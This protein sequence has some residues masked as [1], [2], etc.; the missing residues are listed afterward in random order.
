MLIALYCVRVFWI[1]INKETQYHMSSKWFAWLWQKSANVF[2]ITRQFGRQAK[3]RKAACVSQSTTQKDFQFSLI[4]GWCFYLCKFWYDQFCI[5][6]NFRM[7]VLKKKLFFFVLLNPHGT[8][9]MSFFLFLSLYIRGPHRHHRMFIHLKLRASHWASRKRNKYWAF[10]P[11]NFVFNWTCGYFVFTI[12]I[13]CARITLFFVCLSTKKKNCWL[14]SP[15]FI[16]HGKLFTL[17]EMNFTLKTGFRLS[18]FSFS[19][20]KETNEKKRRI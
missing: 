11:L 20:H 15:N 3:R 19:L 6:L 12:Y 13:L 8:E 1:E 18:V 5:L 17:N 10:F 4:S 7:H 16:W 9:F 2:R 14:F